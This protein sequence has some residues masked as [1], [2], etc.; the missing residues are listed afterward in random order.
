MITPQ[1]LVLTHHDTAPSHG[2]SYNLSRQRI[3]ANVVLVT[4]IMVIGGASRYLPAVLA[5]LKDI[6]S[7]P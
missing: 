7:K 1:L 5:A 6:F 2:A 3:N 4:L